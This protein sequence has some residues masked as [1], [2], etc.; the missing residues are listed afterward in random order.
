MEKI[1]AAQGMASLL[2]MLLA[3]PF[4]KLNM[5]FLLNMKIDKKI[6]AFFFFYVFPLNI[7]V[8]VF[9][10]KAMLCLTGTTP[11]L[12]QKVLDVTPLAV[13]NP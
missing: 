9:W 3:P 11:R 10:D 4:L 13:P 12:R 8:N 2:K 5:G 7:L 6:T 1:C